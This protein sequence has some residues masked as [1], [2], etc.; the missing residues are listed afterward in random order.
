MVLEALTGRRFPSEPA[1][2]AGFARFL[3]RGR[4]FPGAVPRPGECTSGRLY[5]DL[6]ARSLALLDAFEG[7]LYE[8]RRVEVRNATGQSRA[9]F[10]YLLSAA[11]EALL[12]SQPW[13]RERFEAEQLPRYLEGCRAFRRRASRG[14]GRS[15]AISS[16]SR[17]RPR[18][19]A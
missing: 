4:T 9:A 18:S 15:S 11:H 2:L 12:S 8:R 13:E 3:L 6:D 10:A 14:R 7:E 17:E 1:T 16:S 19:R 5:H